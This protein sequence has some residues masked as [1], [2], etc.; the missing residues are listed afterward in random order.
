MNRIATRITQLN[1]YQWLP[2][3]L[4]RIF[5]GY[6]F[7]ET[8]W[9]KLHNLQT[10]TERFQEWGIPFP[11]FNAALSAGAEC[12]CGALVLVGLATRFAS[13]PMVINMLVAVITVKAKMATGVNDYFEMDEPLYALAFAW[14]VFSGPGKVSLDAL[15]TRLVSRRSSAMVTLPLQRTVAAS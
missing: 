9:A 6:F 10:F 7:T 13:V 14:L 3:L 15:I 2:V 5:V 12:F 11:A 1:A 8:G 4:M